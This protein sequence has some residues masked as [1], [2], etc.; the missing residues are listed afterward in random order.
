[1]ND[2]SEFEPLPEKKKKWL[3][4]GLKLNTITY[5]AKW[6]SDESKGLGVVL[7]TQGTFMENSNYGIETLVPDATVNDVAAYGLIRYDTK[8]LNLLG[9][10]RYNS[11]DLTT[12]TYSSS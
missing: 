7:G 12:A 3:A 11:R 4:I 1:L 10:I 9:G 2:R 6:S 5:D 8:K